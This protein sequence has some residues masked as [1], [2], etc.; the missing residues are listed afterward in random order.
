M[1]KPIKYSAEVRAR[2]VRRVFEHPAGHASRWAT[3]ASIAGK[4]GCTAQMLCNRVRRV[5]RD[6]GLR[7]G[8]TTGEQA[9]IKVLERENRARRQAHEVLRKASA[10]FAQAALE[11]PRRAVRIDP[12]HRATGRC[13]HRG[14]GG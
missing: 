4:I 7:P 1:N 10:Y 11:R 9:W 6:R 5:E 13:R 2:A 12:L 8:L 14:V 3:I